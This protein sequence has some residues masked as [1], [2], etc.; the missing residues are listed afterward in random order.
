MLN[1]VRYTRIFRP[2]NVTKYALSQRYFF[3][4]IKIDKSR[5][6]DISLKKYYS[7]LLQKVIN[8]FS[9]RTYVY[10]WHIY[11]NYVLYLYI[12]ILNDIRSKIFF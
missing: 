12:Y 6:N 3:T 8:S 4:N 11:F 1:I 5:C 7:S 10:A 9:S 2:Y